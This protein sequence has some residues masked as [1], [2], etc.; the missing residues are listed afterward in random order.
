MSIKIIEPDWPAPSNVKAVSTTRHG[1]VS[2]GCYSSLNLGTHVGDDSQS[3]EINRQRLCQQLG[4]NASPVWLE[5]VHGTQVLELTGKEGVVEQADASVTNKPG[6]V[7]TVMTADCLPV[8]FCSQGGDRVGVAHA[9]WRGLAAGVLEATVEAMNVPA[10]ELL[11]WFGPAIGAKA[12]EVGDEVRQAFID[13]QPFAETAFQR[14]NND[15]WFAD[16]YM[17]AWQRLDR[18]G[19]ASVSGGD[20]CTYFEKDDFFSYRRDGVTGRMATLVWIENK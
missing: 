14:N 10:N 8:V 7:C 19:V 5:Q 1:G 18:L 3:V 11:A 12:F 20:R 13:N 16:I 9:G 17:L 2:Q 4:I 15:R 6:V